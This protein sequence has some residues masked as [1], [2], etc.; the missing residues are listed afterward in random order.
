MPDL[1]KD[2]ITREW[3]IVATE[4]GRRPDQFNHERQAEMVVTKNHS[5]CPFCPGNESMTP[6][7]VM[8]YRPGGGEPN[9]PGWSLRVVPNKF[10]ALN[11]ESEP[12][13]RDEGVYDTMGGF[14]V[15]EV[16]VEHP[17]HNKD[18]YKM[19]DHE[20]EDVIWAYRDRYVDLKRDTRLMHI[21]VFRNHGR[22]AG[23]SIE[24][25]HSQLIGTPFVPQMIWQI[26][27]GAMQYTDYRDTC[28]FCDIVKYEQEVGARLISANDHFVSVAPYAS[29]V[30]FEISIIPKRHDGCF[31]NMTREEVRAFAAILK[32]V[33]GRLAS[34]LNDPPYNYNFHTSPINEETNPSLHWH[35]SL[36]PRLT[37]AAGFEMGTGIYIN[38]TPPEEAAKYLREA[39]LPQ[40]Q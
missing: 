17:D 38:V 15:H 33:T 16:I 31:A 18:L 8:A 24:H 1:R 19:T 32:D 14:G 12:R 11:L 39:E 34:C 22:V 6:P 9:S 7:E 4:R 23:A 25:P 2:P 29:K 30:P 37:I 28:A 26:I 10:P 20:V 3:V 21:M 13:R 27:R 40:Q 35:L 36:M 5:T